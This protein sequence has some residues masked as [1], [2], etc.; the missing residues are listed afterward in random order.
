M[1]HAKHFKI[2]MPEGGYFPRV[3][4]QI[5][6]ISNH[7]SPQ[8]FSSRR[9]TDSR[10]QIDRGED[11]IFSLSLSTCSQLLKQKEKQKA[12]GAAVFIPR[13]LL[14]NLHPIRYSTPRD[15]GNERRREER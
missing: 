9:Q 1:A 2:K 10:N 8:R 5:N 14:S 15:V 4:T 6:N 12:R 7:T 13:R 11:F 3:V